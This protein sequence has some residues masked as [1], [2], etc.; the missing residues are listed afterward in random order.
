M[1]DRPI[2]WLV[3]A[4]GLAAG[5]GSSASRPSVAQ[6]PPAA[7]TAHTAPVKPH[8]PAHHRSALPPANNGSLPQTDQRPSSARRAFR[9][10]MEALWAG[11]RGNSVH[12]ALAAFFPQSAYAQVKA[13]ADPHGDWQD[14]LVGGYAQDLTAAH[15]LLGSG[16]G[17]AQLVEVNVPAQYAHWVPPGSC[18]NRLGYWEVPN[19]R[20]V[21]RVHGELRS[22]GIASLI[23]WRGYWYVVHLGS[24]GGGGGVVDDPQA[25][26]GTAAP[27]STC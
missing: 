19:S 10:E 5:C 9:A 3:L 25:G 24:V 4:A 20:V 17:D 8:R 18:S 27:S 12:S 6:S 26:K 15:S 2:A 16:A 23:S 22:F 14:R 11:V 1:S 13:I 7:A 21:Y